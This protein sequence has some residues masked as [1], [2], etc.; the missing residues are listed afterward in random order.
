MKK[1]F[2]IVGYT[3]LSI[4]L[5][6]VIALWMLTM[7]KY[8]NILIKKVS[9]YLTEKLQTKVEVAH[10]KFSFFNHFNIDGVYIEDNQHDTLA[11]I[12]TLQL[13]STDLL[14][15]YWNDQTPIIKHLA[16]ENAFVYMNRGKDSATWNYDFLATAFGSNNIDTIKPIEQA[17]KESTS[18]KAMIDLKKLTCKNVKFYMNDAWVGR[19]M[20][21]NVGSLNLDVD[22]FDLA[23]KITLIK[24]L[25]IDGAQI[26]VKEYEGGEPEDLTPDDTSS[27]GTPFNA[28]NVALKLQSL[29]LTNS[30]FSY[31]NGVITST[32]NEFDPANMQYK[33]IN[34]ALNN[35]YVVA[36]TIFTDINQFEVEERCG[37]KIKSLTAHVKFSQIQA[38]LSNLKLVTN[39]SVVEDHF[40]M[41]YKNF[42]DFNHYIERVNMIA[43]LKNSNV[44]SIDIAYFANTL[45]QYPIAVNIS[46]DA[47]GTVNN[48]VME[49]MSLQTRNTSFLGNVIIQG[50]PDI[51]QTFFKADITRFVSSGSDL[52]A[53]IPQTKV[54]GIAWNELKKIEYNGSF[55]GMFDNFKTQGNLLTSLG[56]ATLDLALDLKPKNPTYAGTI[57]T[58]DFNIGKLIQQ[59]TIGHVSMNGNIK[60]SGFDL[61]SLN[62]KLDASISKIEIDQKTYQNLTVNGIISNK[63][64]DGIFVSQDPNMAFNFNGILDISG[65]EPSLNL[66]S[67]II[68]FD[69][70]KLGLTKES[71]VISC[72]ASLNFRGN[73][74]DNFLGEAS[75]KNIILHT[76]DNTL[77]VDSINLQSTY[78]NS[79]KLIQLKSSIADAEIKGKF[80]ISELSSAFQLYL[81]HYLPHYIKMPNKIINEQF[82]YSFNVKDADRVLN[83]FL[84]ALKEING[85]NITGTLNTYEKKFSM[86]AYLPNIAYDNIKFKEVYVVSAG[87]FSSFDMNVLSKDLMYNNETIIPSFQINTT[88]AQ[89]T[90]S[91]EINTQSINDLLGNA[92]VKLKGTAF[93]N[94]LYVNLLPSNISLKDDI[95][96]LYSKHEMIFG[97]DVIV[98]DLIIESGA[99]K[100]TV[101]TEMNR[102]NDLITDIENIDLESISLYAGLTSPQYFGRISGKVKV[103]DFLNKPDIHAKI[104]STNEISIDRDTMGFVTLDASY[105]LKNN[106]IS[107]DKNT[108]INKNN[109]LTFV[110]GVIDLKDSTVNLKASMNNTEISVINQ[111]VDDYIQHL[112]GKITGNILVKGSLMDPNISGS[113]KLRNAGLKVI[114]LGTTMK[115][116]EANFRFNNEKIEMDDV[117]IYDERGD[118]YSG[119]VKGLITHKNFSHFFLNLQLK[120]DDLLC[121]NTN[122]WDSDLFYG[123][124]HAKVSMIIR[125]ELND[126][127]M[128]IDAKPL[129]GSS[130]YL[131]LG[132][133]GDASKFE[134][135]KFLEI[136]RKQ[137]EDEIVVNNYLKL[138]MNIEATPNIETI[139]VMDKNTG[140]E[141]I[142]KGNGDIKLVVD[143]GNT[144]E[145]YGNYVITE[146]KYLFK[147]RGVVNREF[148]IEEGSRISWTGDA[149]AANMNVNAIYELSKP[150]ALYPLVSSVELDDADKSEAQRTY[151]TL[152]PLYLS[153]SLSQPTI[154]FDIQQPENKSIGSAGYTKLQQ[155]RNDEKELFNQ[156]GVLLLLGD[157]KA[158][159]GLSST[160]YSQGAVST[161]SDLVGT[162]VSSEITNQFQNLTGLKNISL[163]LGYQS[164]SSQANIANANRNQFSFNVS[165]NLLKERVIVD[166][167]NSVDVGKDATGN[168]TSNFNGDFKAQFLITN[169]GRFRANA[170][171]TNNVDIGGSPYTRG[172]VGLS[173]KKVFNSFADLFSAKKKV[174]KVPIMDSLNN[175]SKN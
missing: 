118:A 155:I 162:A 99:Q 109:D 119:V 164:L 85:T 72:L 22:Q 53:L 26:L 87:D 165:A 34:I 156:A 161:V 175:I 62:T 137:V 95:W 100:I 123:Y 151:R 160:T 159:Q 67:R 43:H 114:M 171:R 68:R 9:A 49:Q 58:S 35:T 144:L 80:N 24:N 167:G 107:I 76:K 149:L 166:F 12:G 117:V 96:Q 20:Q 33:N 122:E 84:P 5:L 29:T 11:Y 79:E 173:Y 36:D 69:L 55:N 174:K 92:S 60:G 10:V 130:F 41:Q 73:N 105:D 75:L 101:N 134:Y 48:L 45:N 132:G 142:A 13:K 116:K 71:T 1:F 121:L 51:N 157:F 44:S 88:M 158:S 98:E 2:K 112:N 56:N 129:I 163:N 154:K 25:S 120:S 146:G 136:G 65:K 47:H 148:K 74:I 139:I 28:G 8:Q 14:S 102:T 127:V 83:I 32:P 141:I 91:L 81:C 115:I 42:H 4:L 64:F 168:T 7:E 103:S 93:N 150:L 108:S 172:G 147:F 27:W 89:D 126:L 133:A 106:I 3:I 86:D 50:L 19:D 21:F 77:L 170:Y 94:K 113:V 110:S 31:Q 152:V 46:G 15:A 23:K 61:N 38:Q 30:N 40:E 145:M 143:L 97:E 16:I 70:Q 169:D 37:M 138:T 90:A 39:H 104:F 57:K 59:T 6:V 153:G 140:E 66:N 17:P 124:V 111:F 128:D 63:K 54:D 131:P 78:L 18:T 125:G 82:T 52:N 135:V